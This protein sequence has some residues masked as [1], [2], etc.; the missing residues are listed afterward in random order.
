MDQRRKVAVEY[1][2]TF[3]LVP[4]LWGGDDF[5]A[6]DCSGLS[7]EILKAVG[8]LPHKFDATAND[9]YLKFKNS[10]TDDPQPG[11]LVFWFSSGTGKAIHVEMISYV[12]DD[13]IFTIGSSGGGSKT[14]T[15]QDAVRDN[16]FV[17][18]RPV[19]YRGPNYKIVDPFYKEPD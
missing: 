10:K 13:I 4:Y 16:A 3:L 12:F 1:L 7:I 8:I 2:R 15:I 18:I 9:L 17:K 11:D 6:V 19:I 5:S 14:K